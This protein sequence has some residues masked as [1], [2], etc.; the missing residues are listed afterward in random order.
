MKRLGV[1]PKSI[2]GATKPVTFMRAEE[3]TIS[4]IGLPFLQRINVLPLLGDT[5]GVDHLLEEGIGD[6]YCTA[7]VCRLGGVLCQNLSDGVQ[8]PVFC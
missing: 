6:R 5:T 1:K 3:A 7:N 2:H 4:E 8:G